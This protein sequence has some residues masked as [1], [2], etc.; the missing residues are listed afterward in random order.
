M[1][2]SAG[3]ETTN[4]SRVSSL[5]LLDFEHFPPDLT[6]VLSAAKVE[7]S[8]HSAPLSEAIHVETNLTMFAESPA[9]RESRPC[10]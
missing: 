4:V 10:C 9:R 5:I 6:A 8:F 1:L 3:V 7:I 2:L